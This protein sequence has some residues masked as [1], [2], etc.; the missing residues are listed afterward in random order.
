MA[1]P[2][3]PRASS[4]ASSVADVV[5]GRTFMLCK[6]SRIC[7]HV[8]WSPHRIKMLPLDSSWNEGLKYMSRS[9]SSR[10]SARRFHLG[11]SSSTGRRESGTPVLAF[12]LWPSLM[13]PVY[14]RRLAL[15]KMTW[16]ASKNSHGD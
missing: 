2:D 16:A 5:S 13:V 6:Y 1:A 9:I 10:I 11:I 3:G 8:P 14:T 4:S 12:T 15:S 7:R